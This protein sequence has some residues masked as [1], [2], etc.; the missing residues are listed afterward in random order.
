ME[1]YAYMLVGNNLLT[2]TW[3]EHFTSRLMKTNEKKKTYKQ[4][5]YGLIIYVVLLNFDKLH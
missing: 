5:C 2:Q 1:V 4:I 3:L